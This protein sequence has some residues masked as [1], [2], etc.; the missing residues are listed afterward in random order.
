MIRR[1]HI[2][3]AALSLLAAGSLL[4]PAAASARTDDLAKEIVI[5]AGPEVT[6][7]CKGTGAL[8]KQIERA[9][10]TVG[11][12]IKR[13][14]AAFHLVN[15]NPAGVP[16]G[17]ADATQVKADRF[18]D[19]AIAVSKVIAEQNQ[20]VKGP[21][22]VVAL[23]SGGPVLRYA[24]LM[25]ARKRAG[26]RIFGE[27]RFEGELDV[28]DAVV[29]SGLMAGTTTVVHKHCRPTSFCD[30]L[31]KPT[32]VSTPK[33]I[34][35]Q[36]MDGD[37]DDAKNPQGVSG[38]DWSL[39]ALTGDRFT[40]ADSALG[41]AA[42][43]KTIY[44][45]DDLDFEDALQ[46]ASRAL[47]AKIRYLHA[48]E[49][50][51]SATTKGP[52]V[53]ARI[54]GDLVWGGRGRDAG[55]EGPAYAPGCVGYNDGSAG[56][57]VVVRP[58][59][60]AWKGDKRAV[61]VLRFGLVD[62]AAD[63][64]K[65]DPVKKELYRVT[66][67]AWVRVNGLDF[68]LWSEFSSLNFD[69]KRRRMYLGGD[70]ADLHIPISENVSPN[71]KDFRNDGLIT[72]DWKFPATDGAIQTDDGT[73]F[74]L[75]SPE[76]SLFGLDVQGAMAMKVTKGAFQLDGSI[77]LPGIFSSDLAGPT[78]TTPQCGNGK[79]DDHDGRVDIADDDCEKATT[80]EFEDRRSSGIVFTVG[81]RNTTGL[82]LDRLGGNVGGALRFGPLRTEG[83]IGVEGNWVEKELKI[84]LEAHLPALGRAGVK[85]IVGIRNGNLSS[86]YAELNG[87]EVPLWGSGLFLQ[88][89]G[90]GANGFAPGK[91]LE[92][93]V[94]TTISV[95]KAV[96]KTLVASFD[97]ELTTSV[98]APWKFKLSGGMNVV[99]Q[100]IATAALEYESGAGAKISAT[101]GREWGFKKDPITQKPTFAIVPLG[102]ISGQMSDLGEL[103]VGGAI[104][105]CIKGQVLWLEYD[106]PSCL[107]K[108]D[109]R[110]TRYKG[111]PVTQAFC[112]RTSVLGGQ[113]FSIG[114]VSR[115]G[116]QGGKFHATID[117]IKSSCDVADYGAKPAQ[118]VGEAPTDRFTIRPGVDRQV[119]ALHGPRDGE[120]PHVV[121]V[122]PDGSRVPM[123]EGRLAGNVGDRAFVMTG[124]GDQ[125]A[126]ALGQ[127]QAGQWR[128]E[129][130]PGSPPV[131]AID[132][133]GVLPEP[134]VTGRVERSS[135]GRF[136]LHH[137]VVA[138]PGQQV[139]FVE[140]AGA[141]LHELAR[142]AGGQGTTAFR[143]AFGPG[144]RRELV[145]VVMQDGRVRREMTV[146]SYVVA[147]PP[148]PDRV[149]RVRIR[150][151]GQRV[152]VSWAKARHAGSYEV[153]VAL[154]DGRTQA[155]IVRG[156]SLTIRGLKVPGVIRVRVRGL[157]TG[158]E[159]PG[160]VRRRSSTGLRAVAQR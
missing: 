137:R 79:D 136:R 116:E 55:G 115:Y 50:E 62:A 4:A 83:S 46:D 61:R 143:P 117:M 98:S 84:S 53:L 155:Q 2:T 72:L 119:I 5:V 103:D 60:V 135:A 17:V 129:L 34:W 68:H 18:E 63:C 67:P 25:A 3:R 6:D 90:I 14:T 92:I 122:A 146:G 153:V 149:R 44:D 159:A 76:F 8:R 26:T 40:S 78:G 160:P 19:A 121:L 36:V 114:F 52:H 126:F 82:Q 21:V 94:S 91:Q 59:F 70:Q 75:Q 101:L 124:L 66:G 23:G 73:T 108:A 144:G 105:A 29:L 145:A 113:E 30:D 77:G 71:V 89:I 110:L 35:W 43:H 104:Q 11:G 127:P 80:G 47:D 102:T 69:V 42:A 111:Q 87:M 41:M 148:R 130:L 10:P 125:T 123:P 128:V 118:A 28:E 107:G 96:N 154:P 38:T 39:I 86:I 95:L 7:G 120:A 15:L 27:Q 31:R 158:D 112:F 85:L 49:E 157:R 45:A 20:A 33:P 65:Q 142:S 81:T 9:T 133:L 134:E 156:R 32:T 100:Q 141:V 131:T 12:Q 147:A 16:C 64:F 13:F 140:R 151:D 88:R 37:N 109:M 57:T 74:A 1:H 106:E 138:Q 48:P 139:R 51:F 22:D 24:M 54:V 132:V 99:D 97:G 56:E 58:P 93:L 152:S 150:R